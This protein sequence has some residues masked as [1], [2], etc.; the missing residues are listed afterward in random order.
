LKRVGLCQK[1]PNQHINVTSEVEEVK[2]HPY[3]IFEM[4]VSLPKSNVRFTHLAQYIL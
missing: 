3:E 2:E 4:A 1:A